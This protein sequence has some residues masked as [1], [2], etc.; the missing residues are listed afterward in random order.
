M[1]LPELLV[2]QVEGGATNG[3][4]TAPVL[5]SAEVAVEQGS[6][7]TT[8]IMSTVAQSISSS[9]VNSHPRHTGPTRRGKIV[10]WATPKRA[11]SSALG[12][13]VA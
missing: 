12:L 1:A 6:V 11:P 3:F 9:N 5:G 13:D 7:V 8:S 10:G 4:S 2:P